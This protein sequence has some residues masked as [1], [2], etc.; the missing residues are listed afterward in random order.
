[1]ATYQLRAGLT[2]NNVGVVFIDSQRT[3][4]LARAF[5]DA[6]AGKIR[7]SA[8]DTAAVRVLDALPALNRITEDPA[9]PEIKFLQP[10]LALVPYS[11]STGTAPV[12]RSDGIYE[13]APV[14]ATGGA[15][16]L[17]VGDDTTPTD[18]T[19][20]ASS[21]TQYRF[22][23][24]I[25]NATPGDSLLM[26]VLNA[27]TLATITTT[28]DTVGYGQ[29]TPDTSAHALP[30]QVKGAA[31]LDGDGSGIVLDGSTAYLSTAHLDLA[32]PGAFTAEMRF[33]KTSSGAPGDEQTLMNGG[34]WRVWLDPTWGI[35]AFAAGG[36]GSVFVS[37][38]SNCPGTGRRSGSSRT[39][40]CTKALRSRRWP[41]R[42]AS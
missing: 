40:R 8:A 17:A 29:I 4:D 37:T 10:L 34:A 3:L 30:V 38:T 1:M 22:L 23:A 28:T 35:L 9:A 41:R 24:A 6:P 20:Y 25:V 36:S 21:Y 19:P 16:A 5:T 2:S 31:T 26:T 12:R 14:S 18:L 42:A 33:K 27:D 7:A 32:T 39:A 15:V 11:A 13:D